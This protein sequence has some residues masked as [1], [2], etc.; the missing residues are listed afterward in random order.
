MGSDETKIGWNTEQLP[1]GFYGAC[2]MAPGTMPE[3]YEA[4]DQRVS[5]SRLKA[6]A[7]ADGIMQRAEDGRKAEHEREAAASS[8]DDDRMNALQEI[9][10]RV[11]TLHWDMTACKCPLCIAARNLGWRADANKLAQNDDTRKWVATGI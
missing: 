8:A 3:V 7:M 9:V 1:Q 4:P 11:M 5:I 6:L 10:E 2:V